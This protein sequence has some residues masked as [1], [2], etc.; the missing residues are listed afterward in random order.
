MDF[1]LQAFADCMDANGLDDYSP[2][3]GEILIRYCEETL[4]VCTSRVTRAKIIVSKLNR[5]FQGLDGEEALWAGKSTTV[6][7][8]DSLLHVLDSFISHCRNNGNKDT[9]LRYKRWICGRFLKNLENLG[10][11]TLSD[12]SGE[13]IQTA[14]LQLGYLRYWERIGPFLRY[15]FES[16]QVQRDF[17]KL[18]INR[19]NTHP[20]QRYTH[21]MKFLLLKLPLTAA[22][23]QA[24]G[25]MRSFC[26]CPAMVSAPV[27]FQP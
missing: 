27:I 16:G 11:S 13:L 20:I 15:L 24:S 4:K 12:L 25:T 17:S 19:K 9:T 1:I 23:R 10:C 18:V 7:L 22:Q 3:M 8:P 26:Y 6:E 2:E 5:L 14:F 21:K